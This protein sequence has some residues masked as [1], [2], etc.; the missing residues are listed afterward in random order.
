[1]ITRDGRPFSVLA[2][3]VAGGKIV[4]ID[5]IHDPDR[6]RRVAAAVLTET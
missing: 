1:M 3:T 6:V 4:E 5:D 2:F